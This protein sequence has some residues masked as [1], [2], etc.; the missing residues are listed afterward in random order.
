[1][2]TKNSYYLFIQKCLIYETA[3]REV[4]YVSLIWSLIIIITMSL[5]YNCRQTLQR[6]ISNICH[7][8]QYIIIEYTQRIHVVQRGNVS[9]HTGALGLL[10]TV[11]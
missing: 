3:F 8:G 7:A 10:N 11:N 5:Y 6:T 9:S 2:L 1:M 4:A